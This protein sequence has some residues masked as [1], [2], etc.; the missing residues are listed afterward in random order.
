MACVPWLNR[1]FSQASDALE[2]SSRIKTSLS[3]YRDFA[4]MS[5]SFR[6]SAL[7]SILSVLPAD[8]AQ[9]RHFCPP[10]HGGDLAIVRIME[11]TASALNC[12]FAVY[13]RST[14]VRAPRV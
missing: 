10:A 9:E 14:A 13:G 5:K 2:T 6:V 8:P 11:G 4:T 12:L 7:N 1:S 3:V